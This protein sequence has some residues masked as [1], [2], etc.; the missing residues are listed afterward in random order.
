MLNSLL[1]PTK[2]LCYLCKEKT[3]YIKQFICSE[4][5][6]RLVILHKQISIDSDYISNIY[7]SANY[8]RFLKEFIHGFKFNGKSYLYKPFSEIMIDT[9]KENNIHDN[10][11]LI[12]FVPIHFR[13]EAIRGYNQTELLANYIGMAIDKPI[14]KK[15]LVKSKW[16]KEQNQLTKLER[17][18]NLKHSFKLR[19]HDEIENKRILLVDD[20]ITTGTTMEECAK[21][22]MNGGAKEV[23]GLALTSS[24]V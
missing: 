16:T 3:L 18:K 17:S 5:G 24:K 19:D 23:I 13:K 7:Y 1:F 8:N 15:N 4:C 21:V 6:E 10:V 2:D 22:L 9:I 20:I 14:S 11:D 12:C